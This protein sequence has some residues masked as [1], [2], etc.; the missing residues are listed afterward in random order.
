MVDLAIIIV[1]YN[2]R[3]IL[4]KCLAGVLTSKMKGSF[5]V[6]VVDNASSDNSFEMVKKEFPK[7]KLIQSDKNLG[8]AGGNNLALTKAAAQYYL[9][10]NT[11]TQ[12]RKDSLNA[13]L[14]RMKANK[15]DI[16][17]CKLVNPDGT[18]QP[19]VGDLP[20]GGAL[21]NW[22]F[23]I[24]DLPFLKRLIPSFHRTNPDYYKN[25]RR[26]GWVSGSVF[27]LSKQVLKNVGLLDG[28]IFMYGEDV[29]Y[30]FR[31]KKAGFTVGWT[32][33]AVIMHI[34]G[35]S[36]DDP[37]LRQWLG[38]FK[39][40]LYLQK[41]YNGKGA[42]LIVRIFIYLSILLRMIGFLILGKFNF[43]RTYGKILL[44]L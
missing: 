3:D 29:D 26:V 35:A 13:L 19:N 36:S 28:R 38:E 15:F 31:A 22:L 37:R 33:R 39:G 5:E 32:D 1:N 30:C 14:E 12:V 24:D 41:K 44:K 34:G 8:F 42:A 27:M 10:L 17:S 6:W 9:L 7:V 43:V 40:L 20:I 18:L 11:D 21:L 23:G 2:T 25:E 4:R 16:A